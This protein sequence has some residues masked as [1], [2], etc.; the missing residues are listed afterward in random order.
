MI[1]L[2][3]RYRFLALFIILILF[4]LFKAVNSQLGWFDRT[5]IVFAI[6]IA[7][8]LLIIGQKNNTLI[9]L[10]SWLVSAEILLFLLSLYWDQATIYA[11]KLLVIIAFFILMTSFCLY[12][13]L[14][15]KTISVTTLFGSLSTYLFIG[16]VFAYIYLF[17][18]WV[19]PMSFSGLQTQHEAQAMY[20]S[21][22]SLTTVGFGEIVP[23]KPVA[24]TVVWLEAFTGQCYL[25]VIIGQLVG[26]YVADHLK[27]KG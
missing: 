5:D 26:R 23:L 3:S 7:S 4:C 14:Q 24:Q 18:E 21:F 17:I 2:L 10:I 11:L 1:N 6:L 25:A 15:D 13:T 19:S 8:S 22:I 9:M 27:I 16:F 20:F 12:F